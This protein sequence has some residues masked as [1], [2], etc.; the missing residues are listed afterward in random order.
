MAI[1]VVVLRGFWSSN[2]QYKPS[3]KMISKTKIKPISLKLGPIIL[4]LI[5]DC[6]IVYIIIYIF[7]ENSGTK[8]QF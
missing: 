7:P 5:K 1:S 8:L 4:K 2:G 6:F 3:P